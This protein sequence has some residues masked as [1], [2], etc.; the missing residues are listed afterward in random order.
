MLRSKL[1]HDGA[2]LNG[3][4]ILRNFSLTVEFKCNAGISLNALRDFKKALTKKAV[5]MENFTFI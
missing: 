1:P 4:Q 5:K 2:T 3:F